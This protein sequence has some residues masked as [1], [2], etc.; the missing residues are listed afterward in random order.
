MYVVTRWVNS[1][2]ATED[3]QGEAF[4]FLY[5]NTIFAADEIDACTCK[6]SCT[7]FEYFCCVEERKKRNLAVVI[8]GYQ[9]CV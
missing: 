2:I 5:V 6:Y 8:G 4:A 3:I 9:W 7:A 1:S